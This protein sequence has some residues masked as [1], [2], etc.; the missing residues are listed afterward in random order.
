MLAE[1]CPF[2]HQ[3]LEIRGT[4]WE[5]DF[6]RSVIIDIE[7]ERFALDFLILR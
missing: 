5:L 1:F 3:T 2:R 7:Q 6:G 4:I